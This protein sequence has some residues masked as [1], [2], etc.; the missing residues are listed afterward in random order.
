MRILLAIDASQHSHV[1][2]H[3]LKHLTPPEELAMLHVVTIP[4]FVH[5]TT[6]QAMPEGLTTLIETAMRGEG[7]QVLEQIGSTLASNGGPVVRKLEI[8]SP[9][10]VIL[11]TAE[12]EKPDLIVMGAR[13]V[14]Q[15]PDP[16]LGSVSHRVMTH[17]CCPTLVV[18]S[19]MD[20]LQHVLLPIENQED[21][22]AAIAFFSK[23]P[24]R[25]PIKVTLIRVIP[26][27]GPSWPAGAMVPESFREEMVAGAEQFTND[28][29]AQLSALGG[30]D[31]KITTVMGA[32]S[33]AILE[34]TSAANPDL[35]IIKAQ[36]RG[37]SRF[38]LGSICHRVTHQAP[39]S[40]LVLR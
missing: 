38:L 30:Y 15:I 16:A 17:A 31:A 3:A 26:F 19:Q 29:A 37:V 33:I 24:F 20:R 11:A 23:K 6:G 34:E 27:S 32:P 2:A 40:V 9:A 10:E 25:S 4:E 5:P 18:K 14:G 22:D 12:E 13:G 21:A 39:C 35:I 8:G 1:A 7:E 36:H 28:V